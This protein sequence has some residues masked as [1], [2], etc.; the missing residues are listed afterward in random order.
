MSCSFLRTL[1]HHRDTK[2]PALYPRSRYCKDVFHLNSSLP[3]QSALSQAS[4]ECAAVAK[5]IPAGLLGKLM[6]QTP[7]KKEL[8]SI[9]APAILSLLFAITTYISYTWEWTPECSR[10]VNAGQCWDF[11]PLLSHAFSF[12]TLILTIFSLIL[13]FFSVHRYRLRKGS[14]CI[15]PLNPLCI[16]K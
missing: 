8:A 16:E 11:R 7:T 3:V 2:L 9:F 13:T 14:D 5:H 15:G 10:S 6:A 12:L 1:Q 4:E